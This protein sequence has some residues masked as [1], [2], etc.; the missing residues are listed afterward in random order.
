RAEHVSG[1]AYGAEVV[2]ANAR[3][4][5]AT[6]GG[7]LRPRDELQDADGID[8]TI[9]EQRRVGVDRHAVRHEGA[10]DPVHR[11][12]HELIPLENRAHPALVAAPPPQSVAARKSIIGIQKSRTGDAGVPR[13]ASAVV[14]SKCF[15][16]AS[17]GAKCES[18]R[19]TRLSD[20]S[21]ISSTERSKSAYVPR[22]ARAG[23]GI[24]RRRHAGSTAQRSHV[25][26]SSSSS[27]SAPWP[28]Q[29]CT[30]L[31]PPS[32]PN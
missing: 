17:C 26:S 1:S 5:D 27:G 30:L 16:I 25:T 7:V 21:P 4:G 29:T 11:P 6:A 23:Q 12:R 28:A 10:I 31:P 14:V 18:A 9:R 3:V 2:H 15:G 32:S 20:G 22:S 24:I 8:Q 13:S 19:T